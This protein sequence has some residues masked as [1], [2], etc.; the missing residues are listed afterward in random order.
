M[1][2]QKTAGREE[3]GG[4]VDEQWPRSRETLRVRCRDGVVVP[5]NMGLLHHYCGYFRLDASLIPT[6]VEH[7][8]TSYSSETFTHFHALL[9][10]RRF[11]E[12]LQGNGPLPRRAPSPAPLP[13]AVLLDTL[14]LAE[15]LDCESV[16]EILSDRAA[17]ALATAA[18]SPSV[19]ATVGVVAPTLAEAQSFYETGEA[20][21]LL[22]GYP[23]DN[24]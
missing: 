15:Y 7:P 18:T 8:L 14:S 19:L 16:A 12:M 9:Q 2:N 5:V 1:S 21:G 11:E 3:G 13:F 17:A 24:K 20:N 6:D 22:P 4:A 23:E 10:E